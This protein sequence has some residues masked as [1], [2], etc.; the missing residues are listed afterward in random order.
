MLFCERDTAG[1]SMASSRQS[2][3]AAGSALPRALFVHRVKR[4]IWKFGLQAIGGL[5]GL[6]ISIGAF[7]Q[8]IP[9]AAP[10]DTISGA[11]VTCTGNVAA[12]IATGA[13]FSVLIVNS[14]SENIAPA[15]GVDGISFLSTDAI[16]IRDD[17]GPFAIVANGT[18]TKGIFASGSDSVAVDH[19]GRIRSQG[20]SGAYGIYATSSGGSIVVDSAGS[21]NVEGHNTI[22]IFASSSSGVSISATGNVIAVGDGADGI[23]AQSVG[24]NA[25]VT[26][27]GTVVGGW[28]GSGFGVAFKNG[29]VNTLNNFGDI[30]ASSGLAII[31]VTNGSDGIVNNYGTITG[32]VFLGTGSNVFNNYSGSLFNSGAVVNLDAGNALTNSGVLS[33]GSTGAIQ[34]TALSGDFVQTRSGTIAVDVNMGAGTAD[35]VDVT[36]TADLAGAVAVNLVNVQGSLQQVTILSA[37]GGTEN[38]GIAVSDRAAVDYSLLF[39]NATDVVLGIKIDYSPTGLNAN[40]TALGDHLNSA[41]SAGGNALEPIVNWLRGIV[42]L[43][44]YKDA[45]DQLSP[46]I[47]ADTQVAALYASIDFSN[48]LMSCRVNGTNTA[49]IAHEGQCAWVGAKGRFLDSNRT[50]EQISFDETAGLFAAGAQFALDPVWRLGFGLGYRTS[51]LETDSGA[52]SDGDQVQGGV[53]LKYNLSPL[54]LAGAFTGGRGWYH[55]TRSMDFGGF[56]ATAEGDY[57]IDVLAGR[58]HASYVF[59]APSLYFKPIV[60]LNVTNVD[61]GVVAET[62]A[63]GASLHVDGR[64]ETVFSVSPALEFGTEWW[65]ENGTLVRPFIRLGAT[66]FDGDNFSLVGSF[67]GTPAGVTPFLIRTELDDTLFDIAA[68]LDVISNDDSALRLNYDGHF[69]EDVEIQSI[70]FKGSAKF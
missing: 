19:F 53:A 70:G 14:L 46:E 44:D 6:T 48:N 28:S 60:D 45:L 2:T 13:P 32:S 24:G 67:D 64:A 56:T 66:W 58:F 59:G 5:P 38:N 17:T 61:L 8:V 41:L 33:P 34:T 18:N 49:S 36:G 26:V 25:T 55:S 1:H 68:G 54:L 35:R 42:R 16:V 31:D 15:G 7:A 52:E 40:Q 4:F 39:P 62:G 9:P 27:L 12:G 69:G 21:I 10:C 22:G 30:S 43:D 37:A 23:F 65:W 57:E 51:V 47:Y 3:V 63:G 50:S 29:I 11:T 20:D